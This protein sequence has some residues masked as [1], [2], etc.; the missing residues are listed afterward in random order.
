M[1]PY[2]FS[3]MQNPFAL[4]CCKWH[5]YA[6]VRNMLELRYKVKWDYDRD[7]ERDT[8]ILFILYTLFVICNV[9]V[10]KLLYLHFV[11]SKE[12]ETSL[13]IGAEGQALLGYSRLREKAKLIQESN[14]SNLVAFVTNTLLHWHQVFTQRFTR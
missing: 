5:A 7:T 4:T 8:D 9:F 3:C 10:C 1:I 11:F 6:L 12:I 2:M 13:H 14:C